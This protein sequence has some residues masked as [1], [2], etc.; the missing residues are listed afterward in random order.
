MKIPF[1]PWMLRAHPRNLTIDTKNGHLSKPSCEIFILVFGGISYSNKNGVPNQQTPWW[2]FDSRTNLDGK[3]LSKML[4][5]L[6]RVTW[7]LKGGRRG[8]VA[9]SQGVGYSNKS[10]T[11]KFFWVVGLVASISFGE[12]CTCF[13]ELDSRGM[14]RE[15]WLQLKVDGNLYRVV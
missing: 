14:A 9:L 1:V 3:K 4:P 2:A 8:E 11:K 6:D 15:I 5:R 12:D 10:R 7:A 13:N